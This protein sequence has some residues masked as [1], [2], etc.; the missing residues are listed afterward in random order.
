MLSA[1][2]LSIIFVTF[3]ICLQG[4]NYQLWYSNQE[5]IFADNADNPDEDFRG[6]RVES[7]EVN[8][9][10]SIFT[11]SKAIQTYNPDDTWECFVP[12]RYGW[13][14]EEVIV[15][16]STGEHWI[17][18]MYGDSVYIKAHEAVGAWWQAIEGSAFGQIRAAVTSLVD[19]SFFGIQDSVKTIRIGVYDEDDDEWGYEFGSISVSKHHGLLSTL[20]FSTINA[21]Y[22]HDGINVIAHFGEEPYY[23][24]TGFNFPNKYYLSGANQFNEGI[25]NL[26]KK[27]IYDFQPGDVLHILEE[28]SDVG[29][30]RIREVLERFD[31][32]GNTTYAVNGADIYY[33]GNISDP[34]IQSYFIYDEQTLGQDLIMTDYA[35]VDMDALPGT[36]AQPSLDYGGPT[37]TLMSVDDEGRRVKHTVDG[38]AFYYISM[39]G[40]PG[41]TCSYWAGGGGFCAQV[42]DVFSVE[43]LGGPY[44]NCDNFSIN[45]VY[46]EKG[47]VQW[48]D[49]IEW[50]DLILSSEIQPREYVKIYPNPAREYIS[51]TGSS[52]YSK[53]VL[54][55][56]R[57][58]MVAE[59]DINNSQERI[60]LGQVASGI[61][62]C[63][64]FSDLKL[65][66]RTKLVITRN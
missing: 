41:D 58:Q 30:I 50:E 9:E 11:L 37:A 29:T 53:L 10:D 22:F 54:T 39:P 12:G 45:L 26:T 59:F 52:A 27:D 32:D 23:D 35:L 55:D 5:K 56:L 38:S 60:N 63:L 20:S 64:V 44:M 31:E 14:G 49:P 34:L 16:P 1:I 15:R 43:G 19:S 6:V 51:L 66:G 24:A 47:E 65:A 48:G 18:T 21:H 3:S 62:F 28:Y 42:A 2:K 40:P 7:F 46:Y 8:G 17:T 61:Y 57:G 33:S 25:K 4:Q 36:T 13:A